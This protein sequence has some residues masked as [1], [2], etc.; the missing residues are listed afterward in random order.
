M[1]WSM[2]LALPPRCQPP[3]GEPK[4]GSSNWRPNSNVGLGKKLPAIM[5][6]GTTLTERSSMTIT[7]VSDDA[8]PETKEQRI[9]TAPTGTVTEPSR[10]VNVEFLMELIQP[11][12][13]VPVV[14]K[15]VAS[16]TCAP[17]PS[18]NNTLKRISGPLTL[19]IS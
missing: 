11:G 1:I 2:E 14:T 7:P 15:C 16:P 9:F 19:Y 12:L 5:V 4:A 10:L 6:G 8:P 13:L 18:K 3:K 17:K